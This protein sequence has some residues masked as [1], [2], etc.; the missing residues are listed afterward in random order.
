[1]S[2]Q[3]VPSQVGKFWS[4]DFKKE[5]IEELKELIEKMEKADSVELTELIPKAV[6]MLLRLYDWSLGAEQDDYK[7]LADLIVEVAQNHLKLD[8]DEIEALIEELEHQLK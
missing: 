3:V 5:K 4:Q 7:L 1:M 6:A 2:G 8:K